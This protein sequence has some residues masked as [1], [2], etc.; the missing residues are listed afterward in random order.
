MKASSTVRF[1]LIGCGDMGSLR[2]SALRRALSTELVAVSDTDQERTRHLAEKY[3]AEP[4][5]DWRRLLKRDDLD[6]VIV[7]TPPSSHAELC[8]EA[9]ESG[10]DVLCEKPL[11]RSASECRSMVAAAEKSGHMLATGFNYRF[12]P[13][14]K[15]AREL[16]D[17]GIIGDL[18]HI[19]SYAAYSAGDHSHAWLRN[20]E[21]VG[22]GALR[23][24]GIH[25]IDLTR[26][27]LGEVSEV[28]GF[29][30]NSIWSISGCEDNGL[31][32]LR[33]T[34]GILASVQASWLGYKRYRFSIELYGS[35]GKIHLR[36]FPMFT[37]VSYA[38]ARGGKPHREFYPFI[39]THIGEH[40]RSYRWVVER[41]LI[42]E[43]DAFNDALKGQQSDIA[44]GLDGLRA[45]EIAEL[46]ASDSAINSGRG[47]S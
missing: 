30:T 14:V 22:G 24:N 8:I 18:D 2:A 20:P 6:A 46:A 27:F 33:G 17:S 43:I 9:L 16:L 23:D 39:R 47:V 7:S 42:E 10:L 34:T 5:T 29:A 3:H 25:L 31:A 32:L 15:K 21:I 38:N 4:E 45:V 11:G 19:R 40:L 26:Y 41:S 36:C 37:D 12:Y 13:S 28:K 44:T 35:L 1:G